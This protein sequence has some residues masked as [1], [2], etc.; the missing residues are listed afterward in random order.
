MTA[1][2]SI[3]MALRPPVCELSSHFEGLSSNL[4]NTAAD[5][6]EQEVYQSPLSV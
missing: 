4:G 3:I 2:P 5:H 1:L 6:K